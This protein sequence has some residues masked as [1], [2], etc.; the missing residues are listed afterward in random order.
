MKAGIKE[1]IKMIF[2][3]CCG[4][5]NILFFMLKNVIRGGIRCTSIA[6]HSLGIATS[7]S[8]ESITA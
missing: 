2:T 4:G 6:R 5:N 3:W 8:K 7:L 1:F